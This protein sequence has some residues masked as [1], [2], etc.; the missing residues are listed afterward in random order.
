MWGLSE[1]T[2]VLCGA[3]GTCIK[4][5]GRPGRSC[6]RCT[7]SAGGGM[8]C[9]LPGKKYYRQQSKRKQRLT[10]EKVFFFY[11]QQ[12][13]RQEFEINH[14]LLIPYFLKR[15][16]CL[17]DHPQEE[18][19]ESILSL[20]LFCNRIISSAKLVL[21]CWIACLFVSA[22]NLPHSSLC[23]RLKHSQNSLKSSIHRCQCETH[24]RHAFS[25]WSSKWRPEL[26]HF[27]TQFM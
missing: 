11:P 15:M 20:V 2:N 18:Y 4:A 21:I 19:T 24:I 17:A 6:S 13:L 23:F 26:K 8:G 9:A 25:S 27:L 5:Q 1:V 10:F 16:I 3:A 14:Q 7:P 12:Y 22:S